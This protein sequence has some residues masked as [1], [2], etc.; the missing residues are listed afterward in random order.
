MWHGIRA[1]GRQ[2]CGLDLEMGSSESKSCVVIADAA[3]PVTGGCDNPTDRPWLST[4]S[5]EWTV[6]LTDA[7]Q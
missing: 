6:Q 2:P 7:G 5:D 1:P 4:D 3:V